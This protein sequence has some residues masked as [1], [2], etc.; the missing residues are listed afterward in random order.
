MM[1]GG[2]GRVDVL[3]SRDNW[4]LIDDGHLDLS[5]KMSFVVLYF[6][7]WLC[8]TNKSFCVCVCVCVLI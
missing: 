3:N 1:W 6:I 4:F 2:G 5:E 7:F 8:A